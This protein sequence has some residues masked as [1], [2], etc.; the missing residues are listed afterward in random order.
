MPSNIPEAHLQRIVQA[1][2]AG[3]AEHCVDAVFQNG[4]CI[5][6]PR[7]GQRWATERNTDAF[8]VAILPAAVWGEEL[9]NFSRV[10]YRKWWLRP[11]LWVWV[12]EDVEW[13]PVIERREHSEMLGTATTADPAAT[14]IGYLSGDDMRHL[15]TQIQNQ[16]LREQPPE[17]DYYNDV[18]GEDI[19]TLWRKLETLGIPRE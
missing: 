13:P 1:I 8:H 19:E 11:D 6:G 2:A 12:A 14:D 18:E 3:I 4:L 5:G 7:N 10:T 9:P 16:M 15:F 17:V